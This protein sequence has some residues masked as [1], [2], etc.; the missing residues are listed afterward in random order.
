MRIWGIEDFISREYIS[1]CI[2]LGVDGTI[3]K[4]G[5]TT[6]RTQRSRLFVD[7][8]LARREV[9]YDFGNLECSWV[10]LE[11]YLQTGS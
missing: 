10:L 2:G 6:L 9:R 11:I 5:K 7:R 8:T 4:R 3:L 1:C